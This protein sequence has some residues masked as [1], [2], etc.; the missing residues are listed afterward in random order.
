VS[1]VYRLGSALFDPALARIERD[2]ETIELPPKIFAVLMFLLEHR[3]RVVSKR[4]LLAAVWPDV[5]VSETS[6][7]RAISLLRTA[8]GESALAPRVIR[9]VSRHGYRIVDAAERERAPA[10]A[11][12][13]ERAGDPF[14]G[15]DAE[16]A[17]LERAWGEART[18]RG[19]VAVI[20]G[21]AGIGKTRLANELLAR[22]QAD[23]GRAVFGFSPASDGAAPLWP[24]SRALRAWSDQEEEGT[25]E[26]IARDA[27]VDLALLLPERATGHASAS[28]SEAAPTRFEALDQLDRLVAALAARRPLVVMLDDLHAADRSSLRALELVARGAASLPLL[29]LTIYREGEL[30]PD[31]PLQGVLAALGRDPEL[32]RLAVAPLAPSAADRLVATLS[33][34][35]IPREVSHAI[36]GRA[37]GNPL[38]LRELVGA[39]MQD[40]GDAAELPPAIHEVIRSRFASRPQG[41]RRALAAASVIG[42]EFELELLRDV[43]GLEGAALHAAL[44]DMVRTGWVRLASR[45]PARYEFAHPL[46]P[47]TLRAAADAE[48]RVELHARAAAALAAEHAGRLDPVAER[49]AEHHLAMALG[50][51]PD[52]SPAEAARRAAELAER[53]LAF[54]EAARWF[55]RALEALALGPRRDDAYRA[56]LLIGLARTRWTLGDHA[57]ATEPAERAAD[58]ARRIGRHD[59]AARAALVFWARA[60]PPGPHLSRGLRLLEG[61][62]P[63]LRGTDDALRAEVLAR[64]AEH[65]AQHSRTAERAIEIGAEALALARRSGSPEALWAA[66]YCTLFARWPRLAPAERRAQSDELL[67]LAREMRDPV[68]AIVASPLHLTCLLEAGDVAGVDAEI[69]HFEREIANLEVPAFFRWY[70]PLYRAMR[71]EME[72]RYAEAER[73]ARESFGH[74]QRANVYDAPRAL[75]T[76][77]LAIHA[78]QGRLDELER[79]LRESVSR[80]PDDASYPS[81]YAVFLS[82]TGRADEARELFERFVDGYDPTLDQNRGITGTILAA[83]CAPLRDAAR[84]ARLYEIL[85]PEADLIVTNLSAWICQGSLH[86]PLGKLAFARGDV[87]AARAHLAEAARRNREIGALGF[88]VRTWIDHAALC[89]EL[90]ELGE[91]RELARAALDPAVRLALEPQRIEVEDLLA[92]LG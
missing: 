72:G 90:G 81:F 45:G 10:A 41:T 23:G 86:W 14:V 91:A 54:D 42:A 75:A 33:R 36:Q 20:S 49:L 2:G 40:R 64:T 69:A 35:E 15:R 79:P 16:L 25:L 39:W 65:L 76:Q 84:A 92:R 18:G 89:A 4:E 44:Q 28:W 51:H 5:S 59:L 70:G 53:R 21:E 88:L 34:A 29:L 22:A 52:A 38:F 19:R 56:E 48:E 24:W 13:V 46:V 82:A 78:S 67:A 47:E 30:A 50:G 57:A 80:Y 60:T 87:A 77:L 73:L 83:I 12:A 1:H 26:A 85:A 58:I 66:L 71:A 43:A 63:A 61:A 55:E 74:A 9:T 32:V 31:H 3:D 11:S 17:A 62:E 8:L 6:L 37:A 27:R 68:S 7:A